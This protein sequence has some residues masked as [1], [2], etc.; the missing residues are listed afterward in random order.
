MASSEAHALRRKGSDS[1]PFSPPDLKNSL[2]LSVLQAAGARV[3][4]G[5]FAKRQ[6]TRVDL[7]RLEVR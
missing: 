4:Q 7:S 6:D 1:F 3:T 5:T 2:L